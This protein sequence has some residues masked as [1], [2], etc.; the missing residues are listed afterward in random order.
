VKH[1]YRDFIF[2]FSSEFD[3]TGGVAVERVDNCVVVASNIKNPSRN[4]KSNPKVAAGGFGG[5]AGEEEELKVGKSITIGS[6]PFKG[7]RGVIKTINKDRIEVRIPQKNCS[8]WIHRDKITQ[9]DSNADHGKTPRRG[10]SMTTMYAQ[11][12]MNF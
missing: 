9:S 4:F 10:L 2:L 6:G 12:P 11:S 5:G 7:Y 1:V 3:K 8:E